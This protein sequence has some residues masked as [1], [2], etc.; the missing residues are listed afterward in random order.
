MD[1]LQINEL[2]HYGILGQKW[3]VRRYQNFDGTYTKKGLQRY[4]E[5]KDLYDSSKQKL[6]ELKTSG[7]KEDI[8]AAKVDVRKNRGQM[9]KQYRKLKTDMLADKGKERYQRG[10]TITNRATTLKYISKLGFGT[11]GAAVYLYNQAYMKT[12]TAVLLSSAGLVTAGASQVAKFLTEKGNKE[13]RAYYS[14]TQ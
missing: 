2:Y 13:L 1:Y 8:K 7:S 14:H 3:G 4:Y 12:K 9:N 5:K 11:A 6:A 10:E